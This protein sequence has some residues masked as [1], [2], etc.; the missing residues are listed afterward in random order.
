MDTS[1]LIV[2]AASIVICAALYVAVKRDDLAREAA[3]RKL[4]LCS[5]DEYRARAIARAQHTPA[6]DPAHCGTHR[7]RPIPARAIPELPHGDAS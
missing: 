5:L 2:A 7:R 6:P 4:G 1:T 3:E